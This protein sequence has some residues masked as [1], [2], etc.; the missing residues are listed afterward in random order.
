MLG[1]ISCPIEVPYDV[2]I[3]QFFVLTLILYISWSV[4]D[5]LAKLAV[6][7]IG[8]KALFWHYLSYVIGI[9]LYSL[10]VFRKDALWRADQ[11]GILIAVLAGIVSVAGAVSLFK[12][13]SIR[14]L[15]VVTLT[16]ALKP[17][18]ITLLALIFLREKITPEK[19][20]GILLAI[21]SLYLLSR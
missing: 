9:S 11:K 10:Y 7:R 14:D 21:S 17:V 19:I 5:I 12:L 20:T 13:L 8:E 4:G 15:S 18:L 3:M 2:I 6:N 16:R 1:P